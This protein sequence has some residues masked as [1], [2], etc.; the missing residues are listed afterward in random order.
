MRTYPIKDQ[1]KIKNV[2][3]VLA[4]LATQNA[5]EYEEGHTI[6]T[7]GVEFIITRCDLEKLKMLP[8]DILNKIDIQEQKEI[9]H[10]TPIRMSFNDKR[11]Y[12]GVTH[13][14]ATINGNMLAIRLKETIEEDE[15]EEETK[16]QMF[17]ILELLNSLNSETGSG[18]VEI[19]DGLKLLFGIEFELY[20][21]SSN[22]EFPIDL[23]TPA[24]D[25]H[26]S[27]T[28]QTLRAIDSLML[29]KFVDIEIKDLGNNRKACI[30]KQ[31]NPEELLNQVKILKQFEVK[32][33]QDTNF[34]N[35]VLAILK[36]SFPN[37]SV[38]Q[39]LI[40]FDGKV[41]KSMTRPYLHIRTQH[42]HNPES[43]NYTQASLILSQIK[44]ALPKQFD[45]GARPAVTE[46][47][48]SLERPKYIRKQVQATPHEQ[49]IIDPPLNPT[50]G[51]GKVFL[52]KLMEICT[53][54]QLASLQIRRQPNAFFQPS[55][56]TTQVPSGEE[57]RLTFN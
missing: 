13:T 47:Q 5:I 45:V 44:N 3:A 51:E 52:S 30:I 54:L 41:L 21:H 53:L 40:P 35:S 29:L 10:T 36:K 23:R 42:Y 46:S 19:Q 16:K 27:S 11:Y 20:F 15:G 6:H 25:T 33:S 55:I 50:F 32:G 34:V 2:R 24:M 14:P 26:L 57:D 1:E 28:Q 17:S 43:E 48:A 39:D 9:V 49:L 12:R 38:I 31:V 8:R 4:Y 37:N 18:L 22:M 7:E 56:A